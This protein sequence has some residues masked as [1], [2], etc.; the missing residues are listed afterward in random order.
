MAEKTEA[1][2]PRKLREARRRGEVAKSADLTG[3]VALV[4]TGLYLAAAGP[5]LLQALTD[6]VRRAV[7]LADL[8]G[9]GEPTPALAP[10]FLVAEASALAGPLGTVLAVAM[11]LGVVVTAV[12]VGG[13]L[14]PGAVLP[15]GERLDPAKG[16]TRLFAPAR[17]VDVVKALA[18]LLLLAAVA[19]VVVAGS[20]PGLIGL[21]GRSPEVIASGG[22]ALAGALLVRGAAALLAFGVLDL[23]HQ[24]W[25]FLRERRMTKDEVRRE[26]KDQEGDPAQ[27]R[28]R[29]RV[30]QEVVEHGVLEDVRRADVLV[31]NPTHLAAALRYDPDA[32]DDPV[33]SL[34]AKGQG[35]LARRMVAAAREAGVPVLRDVD[36]ARSLVTLELGDDVPERLFD[37]VAAVL[38]AAWQERDALATSAGPEASREP[39][40]PGSGPAGGADPRLGSTRG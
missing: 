28:E 4:G 1:P 32:G 15:R 13:L 22:G 11:I 26:H 21:T 14:A 2:T 27:K 31:V 39:A 17:L 12:Q 34:V 8:G 5:D 18:K 29:Q 35:D 6:S 24:R 16:L 20:L 30:H 10:A 36:L 19:L 7:V 38:H 40:T 3:G 33:P 37:A 9:A 25:R 23:V